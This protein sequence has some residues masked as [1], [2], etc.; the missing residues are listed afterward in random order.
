MKKFSSDNAGQRV[1]ATRLLGA[2]AARNAG[3][4]VSSAHSRATGAVR[5]A[6]EA[7][8]ERR[9]TAAYLPKPH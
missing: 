4:A 3:A 5:G 7:R 8:K 1:G 9:K 2:M 6:I